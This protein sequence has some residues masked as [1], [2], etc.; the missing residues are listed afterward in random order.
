[1]W[2]LWQLPQR[3]VEGFAQLD[4]LASVVLLVRVG[5]AKVVETLSSAT[6]KLRKQA[7]EAI[8]EAYPPPWWVFSH[9]LFWQSVLRRFE[10]DWI[11]QVLSQTLFHVRHFAPVVPFDLDIPAHGFG[12]CDFGHHHALLRQEIISFIVG[13]R[14][15]IPRKSPCFSLFLLHA[16]AN[17]LS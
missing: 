16:T 10:L 13:K 5:A 6:I 15:S 1:M 2:A 12:S 14:T 4:L 8:Y 9:S 17:L 3:L 11:A 7:F